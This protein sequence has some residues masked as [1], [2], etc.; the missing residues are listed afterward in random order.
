M[1]LKIFRFFTILLV[2]LVLTM[3]YVRG[4]NIDVTYGSNGTVFSLPPYPSGTHDGDTRVL[5]VRGFL[6]PDGSTAVL[7]NADRTW[8]KSPPYY[9]M[10][11]A[12][13]NANGTAINWGPHHLLINPIDGALCPD[14][15]IAAIWNKNGDMKFGLLEY[16]G[17]MGVTGTY[18]ASSDT[19]EAKDVEVQPDGKIL[20]SGKSTI[21]GQKRTVVLRYNPDGTPDPTF[22][23]YGAGIVI[24]FDDGV[25][26]QKMTLKSDGKILLLGSKID[27]VPQPVQTVSMYFQLNPNG[28]P[29]TSFGENGLAFLV[30]FGRVTFENLMAGPDGKIYTLS[31]REY[32]PSETFNHGESEVLLTRLL[33]DGPL[34]TS[35]G[36]GGR[37]IANTSPPS[38]P[39][40]DGFD[41]Q[42]EVHGSDSAGSLVF[43]SSGN[44]VITMASVQPAPV[45]ILSHAQYWGQVNVTNVLLLR[46]YNSDGQFVG[47]N[48]TNQTPVGDVAVAWPGDAWEQGNKIVVVGT[49]NPANFGSGSQGA[50]LFSIRFSSVESVNDAN[51]FFDYNLDEIADFPMYRPVESGLSKWRWSLSSSWRW[52]QTQI[53][54]RQP[55]EFEFGLSGDI[56]VPGDYDGDNLQ[57]LA[58]FRPDAG[59]W[60]TRKIYF[61]NCGPMDC[62]EQ[63][64]FGAPGD[65]PAT[66]DFD[67]DGRSDRTVFRPSEGN[68]YILFSSGGWT[69][70]H[71]GLNGDQPVT[72]D[73]DD[74][75]RS[76]VAVIRRE[77]GKMTWYILQSSNNQ[78]AGIQFGLDTDKAVAADYT[79]DG[80]T[81]IAVWRPSEGNWYVLSNYTDFWSAHWGLPGDIPEPADYDGDRKADV[82][83]YRPSE[84]SHYSL[85][86][87]A[88]RLTTYYYGPE[89]DIPVASAY[90]R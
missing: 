57:D 13:I 68:W 42:Y 29:D 11:L 65:I 43:E 20:I 88:G 16:D 26:S 19:D 64:H 72:G 37:V 51:N 76:D 61:N 60:L 81:D 34:D 73:Y 28:S 17:T 25:L 40:A 47:Q 30:D 9:S 48:F 6:R 75:G 70:L 83:V 58:V 44:L 8:Y 90:V 39:P 82:T 62:T 87:Q 41:D 32:F 3:S 69:G 54:P 55:R 46:R 18:G 21:S 52:Y 23:P 12:N 56:P 31:T 63:I 86:S 1:V 24:L 45:R 14:G 67:G 33:A 7:A 53:I 80:R 89:E 38:A 59:D 85:G 35:F 2:S 79:G 10:V 78:F 49:S 74:D 84:R 4:Q 50:Y 66:G 5:P 15:R 27:A 71:F 77:N 36:D 22:G